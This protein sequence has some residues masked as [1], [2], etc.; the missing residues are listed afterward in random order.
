ML[1][2]FFFLFFFFLTPASDGEQR[3]NLGFLLSDSTE[4]LQGRMPVPRLWHSH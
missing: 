2:T 1:P 4:I 3:D